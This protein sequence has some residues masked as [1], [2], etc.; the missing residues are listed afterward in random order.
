MPNVCEE[1]YSKPYRGTYEGKTIPAEFFGMIANLDENLGKL[2]D[3]LAKQGLRENTI[4]IYMTDNGTQSSQAKEIWNYHMRDK[5]T[6]VYEGGHRVPFFIRWLPQGNLSHGKGRNDL[7]QVQDLL[8]TL[9]ELCGLK[10]KPDANFDGI[11]LASLM[12]GKVDSLTGNW[13]S[14]TGSP[15]P[16]GILPSCCGTNG[17]WSTAV[18]LQSN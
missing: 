10:A 7:T 4:L 8:P 3:F 1:K 12:K 11:S 18:P 9:I 16:P 14:N 2:E 13:S 15:V 17:A 6:S 5:K